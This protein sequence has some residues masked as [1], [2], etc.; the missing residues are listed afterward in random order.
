MEFGAIAYPA[1]RNPFVDGAV[2]VAGN[3]GESAAAD[4][5]IYRVSSSCALQYVPVQYAKTSHSSRYLL[6]MDESLPKM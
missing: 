1:R 5:E 2:R 3:A 6:N 4:R